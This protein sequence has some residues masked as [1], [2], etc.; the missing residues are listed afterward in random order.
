MNQNTK[1]QQEI[2]KAELSDIRQVSKEEA[3]QYA[4]DHALD[5][6]EC[7]ARGGGNIEELFDMVVKNLINTE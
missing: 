2:K 3:Q 5:Y 7:S 4:S 6:M 1:S